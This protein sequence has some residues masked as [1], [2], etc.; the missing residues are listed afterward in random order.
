MNLPADDT[1]LLHRYAAEG[2]EE[3]FGE[4]VRRHLNLV[5][6]CALRR[7]GGDT[8]LAEDVCQQV[9]SALARDASVLS[10]RAV[11]GGWLFTT[12]RFI[13]AQAVRTERR[14]QSREQEAETMT[15]LT[16]E[17]APAPDWNSLRPVL[18]QTIDELAEP[19]RE[20]VLLRFFEG[21][22]FAEVGARLRLTENA[23]RMRV[24]RALDK[25]HALLSRRGVN[26]TTAALALALSGQASAA[27]PAGL[28]A[29]V[30]TAALAGG[31]VGMVTMSTGAFSSGA[32][33]AG[34]FMSMTKLQLALSG[35]L[36]IACVTG[37]IV[38]ADTNAHLRE[39]AIRLRQENA[40]LEPSQEQNRQLVRAAAEFAEMRSDDAEF[41][42]LQ[43]QAD[44][45]RTRLQQL[46]R[47][48]DARLAAE[49]QKPQFDRL[50]VPRFQLRP[51]YPAQ[52]RKAGISGEVIVDFI[53]DPNGEVRNAS[54]RQSSRPDFES[55][56][57]EAVSG[58]K[59]KPGEKG[60]RAVSTRMQVPVVFTVNGGVAPPPLA[61]TD[62]VPPGAPN[63]TDAA[64]G[65]P[66]KIEEFVRLKAFT[67]AVERESNTGPR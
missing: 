65:A 14:R 1:G 39:E 38:Q 26:S 32:T 29:S 49:A 15:E 64:A 61:T 52:M 8:H 51:A 25:M 3:A 23:A 66:S 62:P 16:A 48:H 45:L 6:G 34:K 13:A 59:F 4:L 10:R 20:A 60:A 5:Y 63:G 40:A 43:Q 55:A 2:C 53:V 7:V 47:A 58:W 67:V 17:P 35:A 24:D 54:A 27:V 50:P 22:S 36:V 9:F 56:A 46:A 18:D 44:T 19:D 37:F 28:A 33:A 21:R 30:T 57:I 11:L 12:T 31:A 41:A 42:N